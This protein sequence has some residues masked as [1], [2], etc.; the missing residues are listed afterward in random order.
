MTV[1]VKQEDRDRACTVVSS[2][3]WRE[4]RAGLRDDRDIVQAFALHRQAGYEAGLRDAKAVESPPR[5]LTVDEVI[6]VMRR[7]PN[8]IRRSMIAADHIGYFA[9]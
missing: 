7:E 2:A 4:I 3:V 6:D 1:E 5:Q 8:A 9:G